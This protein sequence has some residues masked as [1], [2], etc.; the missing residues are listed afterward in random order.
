MYDA[1][2]AEILEASG[3]K[4]PGLLLHYA[5]SVGD[6]FQVVEVWESQDDFHRF[7]DEV[8]LPAVGRLARANPGPAPQQVITPADVR[9]LVL[10][11]AQIAL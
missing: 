5:R 11:G 1:L 10:T 2:H 4:V 6:G 3:G 9:G 8:V 7:N